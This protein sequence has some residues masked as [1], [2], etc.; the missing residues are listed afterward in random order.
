MR[1][2]I[3]E[4]SILSSPLPIDESQACAVF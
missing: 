1:E 2:E 3:Q 4:R